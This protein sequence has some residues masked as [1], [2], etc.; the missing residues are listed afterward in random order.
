MAIQDTSPQVKPATTISMPKVKAD[1]FASVAK[2]TRIH[3]VA[4]SFRVE[5]AEVET[6]LVAGIREMCSNTSLPRFRDRVDGFG[7]PMGRAVVAMPS[8]VNGVAA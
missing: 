2:G 1:I 7:R 8:R 4:R 3:R 5:K 6:I